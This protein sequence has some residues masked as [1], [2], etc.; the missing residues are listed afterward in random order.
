MIHNELITKVIHSVNA[1]CISITKYAILLLGFLN[2]R[3]NIFFSCCNNC[4]L[5]TLPSNMNATS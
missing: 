4:G 1:T 2:D 5:S 3:L